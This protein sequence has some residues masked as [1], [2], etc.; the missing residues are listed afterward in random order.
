MTFAHWG[1]AETSYEHNSD[2]SK[3]AADNNRVW[4]SPLIIWSVKDQK[5]VKEAQQKILN[6]YIFS[7]S[8][9]S[10]A[11]KIYNLLNCKTKQSSK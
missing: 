7:M 1:A 9:E 11:P 8:K 10:K 2:V 5:T 4:F 3:T 6:N